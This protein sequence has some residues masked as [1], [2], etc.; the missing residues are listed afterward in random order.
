MLMPQREMR[1]SQCH[2]APTQLGSLLPDH[3]CNT[4]FL[5]YQRSCATAEGS[6][7]IAAERTRFAQPEFSAFWPRAELLQ[8]TLCSMLWFV[9]PRAEPPPRPQCSRWQRLRDRDVIS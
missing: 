1:F 9:C 8:N 3:R 4:A 7:L 5:A 2:S 6:L